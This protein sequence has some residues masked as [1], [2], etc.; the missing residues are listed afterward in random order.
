M[1]GGVWGCVGMYGDVWGGGDYRED[2]GSALALCRGAPGQK[3]CKTPVE[4]GPPPLFI[5]KGALGDL[6]V[7]APGWMPG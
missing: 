6:P 7:D 3:S 2:D 1:Y 4:A 5:N